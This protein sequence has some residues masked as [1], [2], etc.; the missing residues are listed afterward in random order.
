MKVL[1][2]FLLPIPLDEK[3]KRN[4]GA[5][6]KKISSEAA[7]LILLLYNSFE[8]TFLLFPLYPLIVSSLCLSATKS[9]IGVFSE[10]NIGKGRGDDLGS[11]GADGGTRVDNPGTRTDADAGV[12]NP[13]IITND[14]G[15]AADNPDIATDDSVT[16]ADNLGIA[17]D[18]LVT[19]TDVDVGAD[20]SST[21]V[22]NPSTGTDADARVD[23]LGIA[24]SNKARAHAASLFALHCTLFLLVFSFESV[25]ASLPS[26]LPSSSSTTLRLKLVLLCLVILVKQGAPFSRYLVNEM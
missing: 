25:T 12:D 9:G 24:A 4:K 15:I 13:D 7:F 21:A 16:A 26:S 6:S 23:N 2:S 3:K 22:D 10:D 19:R 1:L 20:D 8:D 18:N 5:F 14:L 17:A 11:T